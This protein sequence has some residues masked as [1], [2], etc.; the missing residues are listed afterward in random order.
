MTEKL[1]T[2]QQIGDA[3]AALEQARAVLESAEQE[4]SFASNRATDAR[5]KMMEAN[6]KWEALCKAVADAN[7]KFR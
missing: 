4:A 6:K 7:Q 3:F 2:Q 1:P 5:N